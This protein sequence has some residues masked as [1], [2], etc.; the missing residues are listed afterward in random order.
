MM[1]KK[2]LEG[3]I[4]MPIAEIVSDDEDKRFFLIHAEINILKYI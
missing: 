4:Y 2:S 3:I 1:Q